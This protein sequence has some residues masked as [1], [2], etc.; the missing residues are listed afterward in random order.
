MEIAGMPA[1]SSAG[2]R[3]RQALAEEKPLQRR[4]I[5]ELAGD[6]RRLQAAACD[7]FMDLWVI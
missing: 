4:G 2:R 5:I 1:E 7:A 3:L 6:A